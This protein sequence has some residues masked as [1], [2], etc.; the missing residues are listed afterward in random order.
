MTH[1]QHLHELV[2]LLPKAEMATECNIWN[3]SKLRDPRS[4]PRRS[5]RTN[6]RKGLVG[7]EQY[8]AP[9]RTSAP[10][11]NTSKDSFLKGKVLVDTGPLVAIL[12]ESG[13]HHQKCVDQL[14]SIRGP[15]YVLAC[16]HGSS[17]AFK[18][19]PSGAWQVAGVFPWA[20]PCIVLSRRGRSFRNCDNTCP[21]REVGHTTR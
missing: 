11:Q 21:V 7:L 18:V 8:G 2:D 19:I 1:R 5:P 4:I 17:L 10:T 9:A 12:P 13:Q 14:Q 3:P 16:H 6:T 20:A 15:L